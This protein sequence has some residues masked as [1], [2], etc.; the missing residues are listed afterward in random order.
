M[1]L[2]RFLRVAGDY[3]ARR[4]GLPVLVGAGLILLNFLIAFLPA[5]PVVGWLSDTDLLLHLG[6][7][8][9]L[10]GVLLGDAL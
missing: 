8:V 9:G 7:V 6:A 5:W 4:K 10:L 3:L 2:T 1:A